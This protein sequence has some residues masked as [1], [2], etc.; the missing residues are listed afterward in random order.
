MYKKQDVLAIAFAVI[1]IVLVRHPISGLPHTLLATIRLTV[2]PKPVVPHKWSIKGKAPTTSISGL[3]KLAASTSRMFISFLNSFICSSHMSYDP[4]AFTFSYMLLKSA[5]PSYLTLLLYGIKSPS[6]QPK[7]PMLLYSG[8]SCAFKLI[9]SLRY[10]TKSLALSL[11][12]SIPL[13]ASCIML[14]LF[15]TVPLS[16][17]SSR[18]LPSLKNASFTFS[19][20]VS[21]FM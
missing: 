9:T 3:A 2:F 7:R 14:F 13:S 15:I 11:V 18:H 8:I 10:F 16:Q 6:I 21:M 5:S 19:V 4:Q 17:V 1:F 20:S 12:T